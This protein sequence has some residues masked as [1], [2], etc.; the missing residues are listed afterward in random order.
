[1]DICLR[2]TNRRSSCKNQMICQSFC[3]VLKFELFN[4]D[5]ENELTLKD[6]VECIVNRVRTGRQRN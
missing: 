1:M 4:F 2:T 5:G 6:S 3:M